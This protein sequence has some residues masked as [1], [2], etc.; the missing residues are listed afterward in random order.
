MR[1]KSMLDMDSLLRIFLLVPVNIF[2]QQFYTVI[3]NKSVV[4]YK[5]RE[6]N[7]S[8]KSTI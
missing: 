5:K 3:G 4:V 6:K 2:P 1:L 8:P 7:I